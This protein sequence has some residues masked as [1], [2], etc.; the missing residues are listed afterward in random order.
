MYIAE[1]ANK[2]RYLTRAFML[3]AGVRVPLS[4]VWVDRAI[5]VNRAALVLSSAARP[6][7]ASSRRRA[8]LTQQRMQSA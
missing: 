2:N 6:A 8:R 5:W 4:V 7:P 3:S 1:V